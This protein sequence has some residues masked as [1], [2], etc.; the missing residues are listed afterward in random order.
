MQKFGLIGGTSWYSTIDYYRGINHSVNITFGNNTNPPLMVTTMNQKVIHDLEKAD[1]WGGVAKMLIT[2]G[3][4]FQSVGV[5]AV[6]LC[7]NTTHHVYDQ[8]QAA[9]NI[10]VLH[11]ADA[12]GKVIAAQGWKKVGL[13]GT[14]YTMEGDFVRGRLNEKFAVETLVPEKADRD[15]MQHYL[16]EE[17]SHGVFS[18]EA[19]DYFARLIAAFKAEGAEA[20]IL[21]CTEYPILLR[22]TEVCLPKIDSTECHVKD[23]VQFILSDELAH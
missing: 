10:P 20:V 6:A 11:I 16:Y 19:Q 2:A 13:L 3:L 21:G 4:D 14:V 1:D 12:V 7:A 17:M 8:L 5:K 23:I 18:P 9:L 22:D 15:R